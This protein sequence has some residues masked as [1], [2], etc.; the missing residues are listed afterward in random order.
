MDTGLLS[1]QV[2]AALAES[3]LPPDR[4]ELELTESL[5]IEDRVETRHMLSAFR[6]EGIS[7]ALDDFGTG[8]A[9]LARLRRL[10]FTA[11]K[12]DRSFLAPTIP[13]DQNDVAILQA[14]YDIGQALRVRLVAEGV[15]QDAQRR[16]LVELG[17]EE[18]Q[19]SLFGRPVPPE[20]LR[21]RWDS[22]PAL[23]GWVEGPV[24]A[25]ALHS[26]A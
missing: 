20:V 13:N 14:V 23:A 18:A 9:S 7:L 22:R 11:V 24:P 1:A 19:G 26:P 21:R 3:G 6:D 17:C 4:L 5:S 8:H 2:A 16:F 15:E 10:P 25:G 12:L